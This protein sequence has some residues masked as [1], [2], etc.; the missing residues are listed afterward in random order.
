MASAFFSA[1]CLC[2]QTSPLAFYWTVSRNLGLEGSHW[3]G[4]S[5]DLAFSVL[6]LFGDE[7]HWASKI[8][9]VQT[10]LCLEMLWFQRIW[11]SLSQSTT[12]T[13]LFGLLD[14][15]NVFNRA[16]WNS[17]RQAEMD[18]AICCALVIVKRCTNTDSTWQQKIQ[19]QL[20]QMKSNKCNKS[21]KRRKGESAN[22]QSSN[23]KHK[24][25]L[26]IHA[27]ITSETIFCS[28]SFHVEITASWSVICMPLAHQLNIWRCRHPC[29]NP[30]VSLDVFRRS[31]RTVGA[32]CTTIN[33]SYIML[34]SYC[35]KN[36]RLPAKFFSTEQLQTNLYKSPLRS[37]AGILS[38]HVFGMPTRKGKSIHQSSGKHATLWATV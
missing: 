1:H 25:I 38:Q 33:S 36:M 18:G 22:R 27:G 4:K 17:C 31:C 30:F 37:I 34:C 21:T 11:S 19:K 28:L 16:A 20:K 8:R 6:S 24:R 10:K 14:F 2:L 13:V 26:K 5:L 29:T 32:N 23:R 12:S 15:P 35:W 3:S 7:A 9:C